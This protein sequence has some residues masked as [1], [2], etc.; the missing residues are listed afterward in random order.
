MTKEKITIVI[1]NILAE[2]FDRNDIIITEKTVLEDLYLSSLELADLILLIE[3]T[4]DIDTPFGNGEFPFGYLYEFID[5]L[6]DKVNN[7]DPE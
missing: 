3:E 7:K 5:Y 1:Q 4:L 2:N 6:Y